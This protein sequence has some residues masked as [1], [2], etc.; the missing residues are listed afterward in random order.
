MINEMHKQEVLELNES[1]NMKMAF[2][3]KK[4]DELTQ[5]VNI[6]EQNNKDLANQLNS[7]KFQQY[8]EETDIKIMNFENAL[9]N[10]KNDRYNQDENNGSIDKKRKIDSKDE[11]ENNQEMNKQI[12]KGSDG[13]DQMK[14][15][16]FK[17][18]LNENLN[19]YNTPNSSSPS[20]KSCRENHINEKASTNLFKS[21]KGNEIEQIT[22]QNL[23]LRTEIEQISEENL[24]LR[25]EIE[26]FKRSHSEEI[27]IQKKN[28]EDSLNEIKFIY[29]QVHLT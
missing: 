23:K 3:S 27:E 2:C 17:N 5:Y 29:E 6:L 10:D 13:A 18:I 22:E 26:N 1:H 25:T 24:K 14:K 12:K 28:A 8:K 21:I 9:K 4:I 19:S 7:S 20:N 15:T 16:D 11:N